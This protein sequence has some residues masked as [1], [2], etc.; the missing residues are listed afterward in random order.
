MQW[1]RFS[2]KTGPGCW[3][4][5]SAVG[6]AGKATT[7]GTSALSIKSLLCPGAQGQHRQQRMCVDLLVYATLHHQENGSWQ[8]NSFSNSDQS[9]ILI[10]RLKRIE[11]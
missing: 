4:Q 5:L 6:M 2:R 8:L 10:V 11:R 3:Q 1:P 9:P 7:V